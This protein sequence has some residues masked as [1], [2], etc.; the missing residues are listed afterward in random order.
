MRRRQGRHPPRRRLR[1]RLSP[2]TLWKPAVC[3][4]VEHLAGLL[5]LVSLPALRPFFTRVLDVAAIRDG[6][7]SSSSGRRSVPPRGAAMDARRFKRSLRARQVAQERRGPGAEPGDREDDGIPRERAHF[8]GDW[9]A[10]YGGSVGRPLPPSPV[11]A[12][13]YRPNNAC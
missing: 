4:I 7:G 1:P 3:T 2:G 5:T 13:Y 11:H 12:T 10:V 8:G 6:G 9:G